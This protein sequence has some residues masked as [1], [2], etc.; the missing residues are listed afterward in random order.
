MNNISKKI[1]FRRRN[2]ERKIGQS[3]RGLSNFC[4]LGIFPH[5]LQST[6]KNG[7]CC[8]YFSSRSSALSAESAYQLRSS[9]QPVAKQLLGSRISNL[10]FYDSKLEIISFNFFLRD[11]Q[12][13]YCCPIAK[14]FSTL[15]LYSVESFKSLIVSF[16]ASTIFSLGIST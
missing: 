10:E 15:L 7:V 5:N 4:Y 14:F 9:A 16:A 13:R 1:L 6:T 12:E 8:P 2:K 11:L 3:H